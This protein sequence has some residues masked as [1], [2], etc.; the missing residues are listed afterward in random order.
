MGV[1]LYH[2]RHDTNVVIFEHGGKGSR[3]LLG[4]WYSGDEWCPGA[5]LPNGRYNPDRL[6]G[7]DLIDYEPQTSEET[8]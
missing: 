1:S 5:W 8:S 2:T 3:P 7:L 6:T 4:A